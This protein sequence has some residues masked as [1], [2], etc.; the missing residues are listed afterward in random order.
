[1]NLLLIAYSFPPLLDGQ[2]IRWAYLT[3]ELAALGHEIDVLT[4]SCPDTYD[5]LLY[6]ISPRM[7]IF[8]L[9][10]GIIEGTFLKAKSWV[11]RPGN[12]RSRQNE[13]PHAPP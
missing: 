2:S 10:P 6:L 4:I 8:R 11:S 12:R 13:T 1:M 9:Y 5:D 3:R 7:R